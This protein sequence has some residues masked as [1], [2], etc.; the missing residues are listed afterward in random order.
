VGPHKYCTEAVGRISW[1]G[2]TIFSTRS[3]L[4]KSARGEIAHEVEQ[5]EESHERKERHGTRKKQCDTKEVALAPPAW[6]WPGQPMVEV[7]ASIEASTSFSFTC[8]R[9]PGFQLV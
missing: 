7:G 3:G 4:L 5:R 8:A 9:C 2:Y 1:W 6:P